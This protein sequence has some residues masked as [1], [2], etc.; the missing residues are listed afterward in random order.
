[1]QQ[2]E[3]RHYRA[4]D[5]GVCHP[6]GPFKSWRGG[7]IERKKLVEL[8]IEACLRISDSM[9]HFHYHGLHLPLL[10]LLILHHGNP[11]AAS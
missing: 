2:V 3:R 11:N 4:E 1:M 8:R 7:I 10:R 6:R 5:C 9:D